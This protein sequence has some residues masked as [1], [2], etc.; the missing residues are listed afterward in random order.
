MGI[1][2]LE[3]YPYE[4]IIQKK[5]LDEFDPGEKN[6]KPELCDHCE[7]TH[8]IQKKICYDSKHKYCKF[9]AQ[10][11]TNIIAGLLTKEIKNIRL[12]NIEF[13]KLDGSIQ[14]NVEYTIK[15]L[16]LLNCIVVDK[17]NPTFKYIKIPC[18]DKTCIND[19]NVVVH[20]HYKLDADLSN[21]DC[22]SVHIALSDNIR[23]TKPITFEVYEL[24][25]IEEQGIITHLSGKRYY[26]PDN[27]SKQY[28]I[29]NGTM[30]GNR[31]A[32][33]GNKPIV[34]NRKQKCLSFF[35]S[36][37]PIQYILDIKTIKF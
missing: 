13:T 25:R 5:N 6:I 15:I 7:F 12:I 31:L 2:Y 35:K 19:L 3:D 28:T 23:V 29:R 22:M 18:L 32:R 17:I 37:P 30:K 24:V 4:Q 10:K 1:K 26:I 36:D 21:D 16:E 9:K 34:I 8:Y 20:V 11:R 27:F 33:T 14:V